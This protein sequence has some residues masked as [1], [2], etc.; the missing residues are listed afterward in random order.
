MAVS[1]GDS[2]L[3]CRSCENYVDELITKE[4]VSGESRIWCADCLVGYDV[5]MGNGRETA[6]MIRLCKIN[7][8]HDTYEKRTKNS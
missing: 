6:Y 5:L 7:F 1:K 3:V 8:L 4:D 2:N